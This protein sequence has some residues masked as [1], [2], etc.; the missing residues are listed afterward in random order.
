MRAIQQP[1][2]RER[3]GDRGRGA[4]LPRRGPLRALGAALLALLVLA[5][6]AAARPNVVVMMTDD[7]TLASLRYMQQANRLL[8]RQGTF[9]PAGR[10]QL[11]ALLPVADDPPHRPV[12]PQPRRAAQRRRLRRLQ[13]ARPR[14]HA[15]GLAP[16]RGLPD[17][18]RG[19]LPQRVRVRRRHPAGLERLAH[20]PS[21]VRVQLLQL[22]RERERLARLLPAAGSPGRVPD[23]LPRPPGQRADRGRGARGAALLPPA[24]VRG[25][26]P[27]R[28]ARPRR[29][30]QRS[31]P[32]RPRRATA[33]RSPAPPCRARPTSTR[34]TCWTSPRWWPTGRG[35]RPNAWPG[36]RRTGAR[37]SRRCRRWTT[38]WPA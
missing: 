10:G 21:R 34:P 6:P 2:P 17:D 26:A 18:A 31:A 28:P 32:P 24:L 20:L 3:R 35:C 23:R 7:Q 25:A 16:A 13:G 29:P 36:S 4:H 33:T 38:A 19:P 12:R 8:A 14:Q 37:S 11:P 9:V 30:A 15:A 27:R 5:A 22:A 1:S